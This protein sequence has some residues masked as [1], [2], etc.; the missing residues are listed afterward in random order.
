VATARHLVQHNLPDLIVDQ[1]LAGLA[2][3]RLRPRHSRESLGLPLELPGLPQLSEHLR[4][5]I[6]Q[7]QLGVSVGL[8]GHQAGQHFL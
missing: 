3:R 5:E 7:A 8:I 1:A 6:A 2:G 4:G